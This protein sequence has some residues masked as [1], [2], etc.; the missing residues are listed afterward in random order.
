MS[1]C[2]LISSGTG[3]TE[4]RIPPHRQCFNVMRNL[5]SSML[6]RVLLLIVITSCSDKKP[7]DLQKASAINENNFTYIIFGQFHNDNNNQWR[8][9]YKVKNDTV[10]LFFKGGPYFDYSTNKWVSNSK[11]DIS[12]ELVTGIDLKRVLPLFKDVPKIMFPYKDSIIGDK[13]TLDAEGMYIEIGN[14]HQKR[15][16]RIN[17]WDKRIPVQIQK[18]NDK[19]RHAIDILEDDEIKD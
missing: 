13:K 15:I 11:Q 3:Q 5:T 2:I 12:N 9:F 1:F 19:L 10:W 8:Q 14:S 7:L 17:E 4:H 18:L 6:K 16:W